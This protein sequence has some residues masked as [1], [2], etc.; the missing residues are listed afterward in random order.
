MQST[1]TLCVRVYV[2]NAQI[3]LKGVTVVVAEPGKENKWKLLSIQNTDSSGL[4]SPVTIS[5]PAVGDC[6]SPGCLPYSL[7][8]VWAEQPGYTML[9]V[10]DV[11]IYPGVE[12]LQDLELIPLSLRLCRAQQPGQT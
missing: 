5:V 8:D 4:I 7:C 3:P 6:T 2:S 9:H 12:T 1:G 11:K 10:S